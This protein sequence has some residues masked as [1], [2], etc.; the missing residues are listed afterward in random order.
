MFNVPH[1]PG[2]RKSRECECQSVEDPAAALKFC[3]AF[4]A[5]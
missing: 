1:P 5:H 2:M 3:T 4:Q